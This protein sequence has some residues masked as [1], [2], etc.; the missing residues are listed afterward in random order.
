MRAMLRA[1]TVALT[2]MLV[3]AGCAAGHAN[4]AQS[5]PD[6]KPS[7]DLQ[8][9]SP[10]TVPPNKPPVEPEHSA[11]RRDPHGHTRRRLRSLPAKGSGSS[12]RKLVFAN[13]ERSA[14]AG[15]EKRNRGGPARRF[16]GWDAGRDTTRRAIGK[17]CDGSRR[18]GCDHKELT[19]LT[20]ASSLQRTLFLSLIHI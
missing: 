18:L 10:L 15:A 19:I 2:T 7:V 14:T 16:A 17:S 1:G 8:Q 13:I 20:F 6:E 5:S 11:E 3:L 12:S 9:K 4:Q